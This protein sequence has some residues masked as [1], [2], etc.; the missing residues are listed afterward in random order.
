MDRKLWRL[1]IFGA[2]TLAS[3][4]WYAFDSSDA[5]DDKAAQEKMIQQAKQIGLDT[6]DAVREADEQAKIPAH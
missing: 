2:F 3:L 5:G 1:I 6:S 4:L